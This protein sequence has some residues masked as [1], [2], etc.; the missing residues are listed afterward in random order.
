MKKHGEMNV[1]AIIF[2]GLNYV[3]CLV[4]GFVGCERGAGQFSKRN[5]QSSWEGKVASLKKK[6]KI[7]FNK[8]LMTQWEVHGEL[9]LPEMASQRDGMFSVSWKLSIYE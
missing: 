7:V 1:S 4:E 5:L 2:W 8:V 6:M 9:E 3:P